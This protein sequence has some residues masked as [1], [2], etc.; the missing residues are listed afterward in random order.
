MASRDA[1]SSRGRDDISSAAVSITPVPVEE[2]GPEYDSSGLPLSDRPHIRGEAGN[3]ETPEQ[4]APPAPSR[5]VAR[6]LFSSERYVGEWRR[7]WIRVVGWVAVGVLSPFV[8]G[9]LIGVVADSNGTAATIIL[10][11]WLLGL[12]FVGWQIFEWWVER[13]VLTNKRVML[14]TGLISRR[15][16]MMP[17]ARVTDMAYEQGPL[18][19]VLN[20]GSFILESAGQDQALSTVKP[21]PHPRELYLLFCQ[22]MY[23]PDAVEAAAKANSPEGDHDAD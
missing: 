11:V 6:Y 17:L 13:F 14:I 19:M 23:D 2:A 3:P 4:V 18:G 15:V 7:H 1:D 9:Y 10:V 8:V 16:A 21:L 12:S 20:Y 5:H 22:E